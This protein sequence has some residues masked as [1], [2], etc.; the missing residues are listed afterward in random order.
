MVQTRKIEKASKMAKDKSVIVGSVGRVD[1]FACC[2]LDG[3]I[4]ISRPADL[5]GYKRCA[6]WNKSV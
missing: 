6:K 5:F 1:F 2:L 4:D 3:L